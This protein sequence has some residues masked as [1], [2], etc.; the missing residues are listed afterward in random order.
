[1]QKLRGVLETY[2]PDQDGELDNMVKIAK[3]HLSA[4]DTALKIQVRVDENR[5]RRKTN[6]ILPSILEILREEKRKLAPLLEMA[7][8]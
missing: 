2:L 7:A 5:L 8:S 6:D 4:A 3:L 1:M